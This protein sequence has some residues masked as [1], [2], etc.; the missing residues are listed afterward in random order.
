[1]TWGREYGDNV[2]EKREKKGREKDEKEKKKRSC[3]VR[4]NAHLVLLLRI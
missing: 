3:A 4:Y 1:M 2:R